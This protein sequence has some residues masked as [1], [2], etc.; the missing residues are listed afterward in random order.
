MNIDDAADRTVAQ[1][2][3]EIRGEKPLV[4]RIEKRSPRRRLRSALTG[5]GSPERDTD[6]FTDAV[7]AAHWTGIQSNADCQDRSQS[8]RLTAA[9]FDRNAGLV[10]PAAAAPKW[11]PE[12]SSRLVRHHEQGLSNPMTDLVRSGAQKPSTGDRAQ[13]EIRSRSSG[14]PD[15]SEIGPLTWLR[16]LYWQTS[17]HATP[18]DCTSPKARRNHP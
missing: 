16:W 3:D 1:R 2:T 10:R 7:G 9:V 5:S 17:R 8:W 6:R 12:T 13:R 4:N 18:V 15:H 11:L 14:R